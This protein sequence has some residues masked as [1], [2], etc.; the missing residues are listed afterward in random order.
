MPV[1][2]GDVDTT[3]VYDWRKSLPALCEGYRPEDIFN[4]DETGLFFVKRPTKVF[5]PK[6]RTV[7]VENNPRRGLPSTNCQYD[8]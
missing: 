6:E 1:E 7:L 5:I 8:G 3:T 4:M 2:R